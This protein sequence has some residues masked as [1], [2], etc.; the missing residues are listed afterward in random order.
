M[1]KQNICYFYNSESVNFISVKR[2]SLSKLNKVPLLKLS[3]FIPRIV[4]KLEF[5]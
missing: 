2:Q 4:L 5:I 3:V 1:K